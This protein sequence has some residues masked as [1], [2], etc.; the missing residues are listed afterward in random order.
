MNIGER[1]A[2]GSLL[3]NTGSAG[4]FAEHPALS[5]KDDMTI[6]ELFLELP[7]KSM[8]TRRNSE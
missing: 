5:N 7:C 1:A 8:R 2:T 3:F 6:G 4:R